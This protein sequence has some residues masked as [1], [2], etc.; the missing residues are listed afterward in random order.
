MTKP[1]NFD[2]TIRISMHPERFEETIPDPSTPVTL[3]ANYEHFEIC[4]MPDI[5]GFHLHYG[6]KDE[7]DDRVSIR[8]NDDGSIRIHRNLTDGALLVK[9][10]PETGVVEIIPSPEPPRA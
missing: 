8:I 7:T 1:P 6:K 2:R 10:Q 3:W 4:V 9:T 5:N